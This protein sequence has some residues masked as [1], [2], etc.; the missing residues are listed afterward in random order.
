MLFE[1]I[2]CVKDFMKLSLLMAEKLSKEPETCRLFLQDVSS[3]LF[4]ST[5]LPWLI[6]KNSSELSR[7]VV[8]L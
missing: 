1:D 3:S 4:F 7:S 8:F 2:Q 5:A 6:E